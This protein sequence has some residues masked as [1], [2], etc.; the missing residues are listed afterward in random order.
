MAWKLAQGVPSRLFLLSN[1]ANEVSLHGTL[2]TVFVL[3]RVDDSR[4]LATI[5]YTLELAL[6]H[7]VE[8]VLLY[9]VYDSK[10]HLLSLRVYNG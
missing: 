10:A 3:F 5:D 4:D 2:E 7:L 1:H 6:E 8:R 9:E